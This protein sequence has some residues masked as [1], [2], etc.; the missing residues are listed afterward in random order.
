MTA[1]NLCVIVIALTS[2]SSTLAQETDPEP[3]A[4]LEACGLTPAQ[5][6]YWDVGQELPG[7]EGPSPTYLDQLT[8]PPTTEVGDDPVLSLPTGAF[9]V[10]STP[11]DDT[12]GVQRGW[13]VVAVSFEEPPWHATFQDW[14]ELSDDTELIEWVLPFDGPPLEVGSLG[15]DF[16]YQDCEGDSMPSNF[17]DHL[18]G[19]FVRSEGSIVTR[20]VM[21]DCVE[22]ESGCYCDCEDHWDESYFECAVRRITWEPTAATHTLMSFDDDGLPDVDDY[23]I[24]RRLLASDF[25]PATLEAYVGTGG[26]LAYFSIVIEDEDE[27]VALPF[28]QQPMWWELLAL[29]ERLSGTDGEFELLKL[30]L[31]RA[32]ELGRIVSDEESS[33]PLECV[34]VELGRY[35]MMHDTQAATQVLQ[36]L[37]NNRVNIGPETELRAPLGSQ[38]G[39]LDALAR[40]IRVTNRMWNTTAPILNAD[41]N[42][43]WED[44]GS[45]FRVV[46]PTQSL[47]CSEV[48]CVEDPLTE[49]PHS[50]WSNP[51]G[52]H[53]LTWVDSSR[54]WIK[55]FVRTAD[56]ASGVRVNGSRYPQVA[57]WVGGEEAPADASMWALMEPNGVPATHFDRHYRS[58]TLILY[59]CDDDMCDATYT[60]TFQK[61]P[62]E[63]LSTCRLECDDGD[64]PTYGL[65]VTGWLSDSELLY[66]YEASFWSLSL[67]DGIA[68][69]IDVEAIP[70]SLLA[71][72]GLTP[73][74]SQRFFMRFALGASPTFWRIDLETGERRHLGSI[75]ERNW[76]EMLGFSGYSSSARRL[77]PVSY[78]V[79]SPTGDAVA[80]GFEGQVTGVWGLEPDESAE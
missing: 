40:S 54:E 61:L 59:G 72:T 1:R 33:R 24:T 42:I 26:F 50:R 48:G 44:D 63:G 70:D 62:T 9:A 57:C 77:T 73:D 6:V 27:L 55:V 4:I 23:F 43:L 69:P 14:V 32:N 19:T 5:P 16:D 67:P 68:T 25:E 18:D 10:M 28:D 56:S 65:G 2:A 22:E 66:A 74:R 11:L 49:S 17:C 37:E 53:H 34:F 13:Y 31:F 80:V 12:M 76:R 7:E 79:P 75:H 46:G 20:C 39:M 64:L 36:T 8:W 47:N 71:M 60:T 29:T 35:L 3:N 21:S 58:P 38:S 78:V 41:S 52:T 51:S 30:A 45:A 15:V